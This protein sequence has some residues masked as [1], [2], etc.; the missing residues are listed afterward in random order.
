[1]VRIPNPPLDTTSG[2]VSAGSKVRG[3]SSPPIQPKDVSVVG[4]I[5]PYLDLFQEV[6]SGAWETCRV[7]PAIVRVE[8]GLGSGC[9]RGLTKLSA[10]QH[11]MVLTMGS[12][13]IH[14]AT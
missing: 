14:L 12:Q 1:M 6:G 13:D 7:V 4:S 10:Q 11:I 3:A 5:S 8:R 2:Y 9:R